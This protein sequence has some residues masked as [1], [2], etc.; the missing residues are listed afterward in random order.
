MC[1]SRDLVI[2]RVA[3]RQVRGKKNVVLDRSLVGPIGVIVKVTTLQEY[4][5]DKFFVLENKNVDTSQRNVIFI[6]RGECGRHSQ[7][8]AG[9]SFFFG[10]PPYTVSSYGCS[11]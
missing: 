6:A 2:S 11:S 4:G 9:Q 1:P 10:F 3:L 8:I 7:T 5:V